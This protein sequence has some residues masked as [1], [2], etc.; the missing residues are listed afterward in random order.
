MMFVAVL[1]PGVAFPQAVIP[2]LNPGSSI[3]LLPSDSAVLD[4]GEPRTDLPCAVRSLKPELGF[5][6][7]FRASY[8]VSIAMNDLSDAGHLLTILFRVISEGRSD[9]PVYFVQRIPV[10]VLDDDVKGR[11]ELTGTFLLGEGKYHVDWLMRDLRERFCASSWDVEARVDAKDA[12]MSREVVPGLIQPVE[13]PF[14]AAE[15]RAERDERRSLLNVMIIVNFVPQNLQSATLSETDIEGLAAI[16]RKIARDP[17]IGSYSVVACSLKAQQV[18]Y[19]QNNAARIDLPA[20]GEALKS[21]NL[22]L[23]DV[24]QLSVKNGETEFLTDLTLDAYKSDAYK[25]DAFE[26]D[27]LKSSQPDGLIFVSPKYPLAVDVTRET[28]DSLRYSDRPV[29]YLNYNL[30]PASY[31]W[32]DAI[33]RLVK[34]L[35]GYEYTISRP[36]DLLNAW[37]EIVDRMMTS[38]SRQAAGSGPVSSHASVAQP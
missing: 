22:A 28:I 21:L 8:R 12:Q 27:A 10:P 31:P 15:S 20:M 18:I 5:D 14:L 16:L 26:G 23:V 25:S 4:L 19:R 17:R 6:F 38:R 30:E 24:K 29:F 34:R 32:R 3:R 7:K 33:G 9:A 11:A 13:A 37:S 2:E 35:G 1:A 36:R